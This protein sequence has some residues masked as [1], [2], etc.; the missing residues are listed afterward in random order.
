MSIPATDLQE[1]VNDVQWVE[2][3]LL[4]R[5][6]VATIEAQLDSSV[7]QCLTLVESYWRARES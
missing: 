2:T 4:A 7:D 6:P 5:V 3:N 1:N